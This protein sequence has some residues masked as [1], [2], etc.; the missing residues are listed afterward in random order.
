MGLF[1]QLMKFGKTGLQGLPTG[2]P[3]Y[4]AYLAYLQPAQ[5]VEK[6]A[7]PC[8]ACAPGSFKRTQADEACSTCLAHH[9]C[10]AGSVEPTACPANS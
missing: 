1:K 6:H 9:F 8:E 10:P 3:Q 4:L 5:A 7:R 2:E